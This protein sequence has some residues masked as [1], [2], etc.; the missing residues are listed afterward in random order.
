MKRNLI[1]LCLLF[2]I[3]FQSIAQDT[4]YV[5][6]VMNTIASSDYNGRGYGLN[7]HK[8]AAEFI[9]GEL[10]RFGLKTFGDS[11][12]QEFDLS[13]NT[14]TGKNDVKVNRNQLIPGQDFLIS[15]SSNSV[16]GK[17]KVLTLNAN[18]IKDEVKLRKFVSQKMANK[19]LLID[20]V[21]LNNPDFKD[22]MHNLCKLNAL[23]AKGVIQ[24]AENKLTH[25]PSQVQKDFVFLTILRS[26]LPKKLTK[27]KLDIDA[28][29]IPEL[30][31]QNVA[32]FIKG[33]TDSFIVYSAH[34]DHLG[35]MG[36][37][38]YFPGGN[39]NASGTSM[40]LDLAKHFSAEKRIPK[41]SIVFLFFSGEEL[42]ILGSEYF[43]NNPLFPLKKMRF[44][45]N[46]DMVGSGDIGIQIV[47][48]SVF[49][50]EFEFLVKTNEEQKYLP[51]V[52]IRGAAANSDHYYF[53][54]KG[55][56]CFFIYTLGKYSEYH[57][58]YDKPESVPLIGY[59]GLFKLLKDFARYLEE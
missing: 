54:V 25:A 7:G 32:G 37:S 21:G 52:R 6:N 55:V 17:F 40:L 31:T 8:M 58:I 44:L 42:G 1:I 9:E 46:L 43:T 10:K 24:V 50:P 35:N 15:A 13:V 19:V 2:L 38:V 34:Y 18:I 26:K 51:E 41:H 49:S 59:N 48:G 57:N 47:N 56:R 4:T 12:F 20:T 45:T 28:K 5:R 16:K 33:R 36:K 53:Y 23:K 14:F 29:L 27:I 39:D 3:S 11:Y 22:V 30:I